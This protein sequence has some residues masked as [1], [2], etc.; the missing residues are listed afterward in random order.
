MKPN[1]QVFMSSG[2]LSEVMKQKVHKFSDFDDALQFM[3]GIPRNEHEV[4]FKYTLVVMNHGLSEKA[5]S[6]EVDFGDLRGIGRA[7]N[8]IKSQMF[9]DLDRARIAEHALKDV[10]GVKL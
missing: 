8:I 4:N 7:S 10:Y 6:Y 1:Y 3:D 9:H 5:I 2:P